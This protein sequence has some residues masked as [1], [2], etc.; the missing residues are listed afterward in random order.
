M[1]MLV[2]P[3]G[4]FPASQ[5]LLVPRRDETLALSCV[6]QGVDR[7]SDWKKCTVQ[8]LLGCSMEVCVCKSKFKGV[9]R[10]EIEAMRRDRCINH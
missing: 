1:L 10:K 7:C 5:V 2:I 3:A 4:V 6:L 9:L 8:L